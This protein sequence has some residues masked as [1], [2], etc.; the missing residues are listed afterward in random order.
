[1]PDRRSKSPSVLRRLIFP[2]GLALMAAFFAA[3][4]TQFA[5]A[6]E[7]SAQN[8]GGDGYWVATSDGGVFTYGDARF[9]GS[10]AGKKLRAPITD[11]VPTPTGKG[12]WLVGEDGGIFSFGDAKF[13]GSPAD[14]PHAPAVAIARVPGPGQGGGPAGPKGDPGPAGPQGPSGPQGVRGPEGP[15]GPEGP[16]GPRG[17]EGPPGAPATYV[18]AN[19]G[20]VHRN[21]TGN[22][23]AELGSATQTPPHG[24]GALNIQTSAALDP[25]TGIAADK[26]AFGNEKDFF[27]TKVKDLTKVAYSVYT[28]NENAAKAANNMPS[29]SFEIDP[30][31]TG[32]TTN[33]SSLVYAPHTS[34]PGQWTPIDAL[35]DTGRHWGLTSGQFTFDQCHINGPRCTWTEILNVLN[36][37]GEDAVITFSVQITK[38]RDFAFSGMVDGLVINDKLYDFEP[39]GVETKP[40]L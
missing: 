26:A 21:V 29:I 1:M 17:P 20:V 13:F 4:S 2:A 22:G 8:P 30:N 5:G 27:N 28:T 32:K 25:T 19:W 33:Y 16:R 15:Q 36:D 11:I 35:A 39:F 18:G 14:L 37:G 3:P 9:Y 7:A 12:Y 31:V 40:A 6:Q 10:M 34:T 24:V 38:G 23:R